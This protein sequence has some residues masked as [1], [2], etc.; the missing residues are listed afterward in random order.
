MKTL[1]MRCHGAARK[2]DKDATNLR[3]QLKT[4]GPSLACRTFAQVATLLERY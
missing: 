4:K 3:A 1:E 2:V